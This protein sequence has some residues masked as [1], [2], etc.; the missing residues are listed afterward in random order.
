VVKI[1]TQ[2]SKG[3]PLRSSFPDKGIQHLIQERR[4]DRSL[5][6]LS[7]ACGGVPTRSNLDRIIH[8]PVLS[9]PKDNS[10][11]T[12]LAKGLGVRVNDVINAYGRSLGLPVE[13]DLDDLVLPGAG[14]LPVDSQ[15]VLLGMSENM[16]WWQEQ[17][18]LGDSSRDS[19]R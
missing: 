7:Q 18:Q 15:K 9:W 17:A 16:L 19:Q 6:S 11:I 5:E 1:P 13:A 2:I 14:R 3:Q 12:G 8:R 10:V 4:G